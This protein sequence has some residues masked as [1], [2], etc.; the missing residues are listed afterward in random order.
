MSRWVDRPSRNTKWQGFTRYA[1]QVVPER[2]CTNARSVD[3]PQ[4]ARPLSRP[5]ANPPQERPLR[6]ACTTNEEPAR[7]ARKSEEW[8]FLSTLRHTKGPPT[9]P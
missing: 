8:R 6:H 9:G 5:Q 4:E 3:H 2:C 1:N 7:E